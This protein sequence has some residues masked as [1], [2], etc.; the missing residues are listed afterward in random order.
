MNVSSR[1]IVVLM[2][3]AMGTT[4]HAIDTPNG[5]V[6]AISDTEDK[7]TATGLLSYRDT[8]EDNNIDTPTF[9][10]GGGNWR[11]NLQHSVKD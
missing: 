7:F 3:L 2:V 10:V 8:D 1:Y 9:Q 4:I 5:L 6:T 11:F